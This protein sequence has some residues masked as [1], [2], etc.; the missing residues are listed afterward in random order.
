MRCSPLAT[1]GGA[2]ICTTRSMAPMS[3]P[4]SSDEVATSA[5]SRPAL[6]RSSIS[7]RWGR[8]SDPWWARTSGSPASSLSAAASRS[9][10]RRL[11]TKS[12]VERWARTSSSRRGWIDVQIVC[13]DPPC[14]AGPLGCSTG[15]P[16]LAMSAIG[17]STVIASFFGSRASTT[18]TARGAPGVASANS[19]CR[20]RAGSALPRALPPARRPAGMVP[21]R[22][23]AISSRLRCVADRPMRCSGRSTIRSSRSSDSAMCAPRL[24][25]TSAWISS[26]IT[27]STARSRSRAFEVSSRNSDSGVVI[28]MSAGSRWNRVRSAA[29]VSPVR[30][31]IAGTWW[32]TPA[33][34]A[35]WA[36]PASGAR[37][38][39]ST[40]TA[41][42]FSGDRYRTRQRASRGGTGANISRSRQARNAVSVLPVPV[43]AR[44]SVDWP[45]AI[46][47]QPC[48][49]GRVGPSKAEANQ[50]ATG[51][52]NRRRTFDAIAR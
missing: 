20:A 10:R 30:I 24:V 41:S 23:R 26:T 45:V 17:T 15:W 48:R 32:G 13:T 40:S 52:W 19:S 9:A 25:E 2:S 21:P 47:G 33:A 50:S 16:T 7:V 12:R 51:G 29:G 18:V 42:A 38:L 28:R 14:A 4:S 39:R 46:T 6:S 11:L 1:D 35:R 22:K 36:M 3:M 27:V 43:G 8:A 44:M 34:A 49:W 31:D 37:R 5:R